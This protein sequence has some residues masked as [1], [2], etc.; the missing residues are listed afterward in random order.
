M[1]ISSNKR[2]RKEGAS[3]RWNGVS[4]VAAK[5]GIQSSGLSR[6]LDAAF[7]GIASDSQRA[8]VSRAIAI[9]PS[10]SQSSRSHHMISPLKVVLANV[11][12]LTNQISRIAED[13]RSAKEEKE[14]A[15]KGDIREAKAHDRIIKAV[16]TMEICSSHRRQ[17]ALEL[18]SE[19]NSLVTEY[20]ACVN[21]WNARINDRIAV[22]K[23]SI[24]GALLPYFDGDLGALNVA[25]DTMHIPSIYRIN[26]SRW[27]AL[28]PA[29]RQGTK[30]VRYND[31]TS[32]IAESD[33]VVPPDKS[34]WVALAIA[35]VEHVER[36][37]EECCINVM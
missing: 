16:S 30:T 33:T 6:A 24:R 29:P 22:T 28:T 26:K 8:M 31:G 11:Q 10:L 20:T 36:R 13:E 23:S 3:T 7:S 4:S 14:Q 17:I 21:L 35:F 27:A 9:L 25:M 2:G 5:L 12:R 32:S 15:A 18:D 1:R 37:A 34:E 19:L